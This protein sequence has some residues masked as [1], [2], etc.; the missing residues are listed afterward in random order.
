[1][2]TLH[3]LDDRRRT[4][5]AS[6]LATTATPV[7][8]VSATTPAERRGRP[9]EPVPAPSLRRRTAEPGARSSSA[10]E[11]LWRELLGPALRL[12][13]TA[14]GER[15]ADVAGRAGVSP[16]YLSEVERG[17]KDASSEVLSACA[18]ALGLTVTEVARRALVTR[19][20]SGRGPEARLLAG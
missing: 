1:M 8:P 6:P 7:S 2:G 19:T 11:P 5:S 17:R 16:Q 18:G 10:P 3:R 15:I 13:R 20:S 9:G 4:R 12:E 14:R